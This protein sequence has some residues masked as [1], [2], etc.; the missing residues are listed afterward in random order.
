V[1]PPSLSAPPRT[2]FQG[3]SS[4]WRARQRP[5]VSTTS[6]RIKRWVGATQ[7]YDGPGESMLV[8]SSADSVVGI[9]GLARCPDGPEVLRMRRSESR[10]NAAGRPTTERLTDRRP[11][12]RNSFRILWHQERLRGQW[13]RASRGRPSVGRRAAHPQEEATTR[14][15]PTHS[16]PAVSDSINARITPARRLYSLVLLRYNQTHVRSTDRGVG[17]RQ[18][19]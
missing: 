17:R 10:I 1:V 3:S 12:P 8:A 4:S 18:H 2:N 7:R 15:I 6:P 9:G 19:R 16:E 13:A 11:D 14:D 5:Q